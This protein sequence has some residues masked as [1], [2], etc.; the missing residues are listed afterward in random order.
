MMRSFAPCLAFVDGAI[1]SAVRS[2]ALFSLQARYGVLRCLLF[3]R[4]FL[5][6]SIFSLTHQG[7]SVVMLRTTYFFVRA[8]YP[9]RLLPGSIPRARG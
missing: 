9:S 4:K 8:V 3:L 7:V 2:T 5:R 6:L 1:R